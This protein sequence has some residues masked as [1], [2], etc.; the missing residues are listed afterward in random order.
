MTDTQPAKKRKAPEVFRPRLKTEFTSKALVTL[1]MNVFDAAVSRV[2]WLFDEFDGRVS[3]SISGGKDSTVIM[4][5]AAMVARERGQRLKVQFLDQEAEWQGT[6]DYLRHLKDD[7]EDLDFDWYQI[8]FRLFNAASHEDE[9]G[10]MWEEGRPDDY[11]MR[12]PEP[13]SIRVNDFGV[14][15]FSDVLREMNARVGGA[16]LTG[17]RAEES[18][19]RRLG[20]TTRPAYKW[21]T[22]GAGSPLADKNKPGTFWLMHPIYDWSFRD[23]WQAIEQNG[24]RYN[25]IYDELFRYGTS[26]RDMRVSSLIHSGAVRH[27]EQIQEIEPHTWERLSIRFAGTNAAAHVGEDSLAEFRGKR[28]FM[29]DTWEEYWAYLIENLIKEEH[30]EKFYGMMETAKA[31]LPW[32]HRDRI[33]QKMLP[34]VMKNDYFSDYSF[35]KW[36]TASVQWAEAYQRQNGPLPDDWAKPVNR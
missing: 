10:Y 16:H 30:R 31:Q 22:W 11:Y 29:F 17:M 32:M 6:R 5:I 33:A 13:D 25:R 27:I 4:E 35:S 36:V 2:R 12:P 15:R 26:H 18:P 34:M 14:D 9:W 28:P 3:V 8:P 7:R 21:A 23:V 1:D 24:W 19:T 20:M